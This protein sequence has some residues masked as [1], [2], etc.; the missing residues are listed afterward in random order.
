[1]MFLS[2]SFFASAIACSAIWRPA[3][4]HRVGWNSEVACQVAETLGLAHTFLVPV[5]SHC[6]FACF[7]S[8]NH[9][10]ARCEVVARAGTDR[11]FGFAAMPSKSFCQPDRNKWVHQE[12]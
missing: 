4:C 9:P 12:A 5:L 8:Q 1:M 10:C 7:Q 2:F 11:T 6:L 3:F